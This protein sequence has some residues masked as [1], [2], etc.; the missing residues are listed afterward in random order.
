[1]PELMRMRSAYDEPEAA[2]DR[3]RSAA[4]L[5]SAHGS[6]ALLQRCAEDLARRGV[7]PATG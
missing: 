5:A 6:V 7:R 3:L 2:V 1:M 4:R